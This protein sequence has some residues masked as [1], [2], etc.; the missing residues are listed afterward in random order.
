VD[1]SIRDW[2]PVLDNGGD[3]IFT[4]GPDTLVQA[5]RVTANG[6]DGIDVRGPASTLTRNSA[7]RNADLGIEAITEVIDDGGNRAFGNGNPL[8]CL[9][10]ACK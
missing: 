7:K 1:D 2:R 9:N 8:Q 3:G 4:N 6:D 5:N 10:V